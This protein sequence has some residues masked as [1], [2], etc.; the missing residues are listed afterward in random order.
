MAVQL[1]SRVRDVFEVDLPV[2][3][4]L[5]SPTIMAMAEAV[6]LGQAQAGKIAGV[7]DL[8]SEIEA[9]GTEEAGALLANELEVSERAE[10]GDSAAMTVPLSGNDRIH[11][12]SSSAFSFSR[13]TSLR[14][15][16]TNTSSC[17]KRRSSPIVTALLQFGR[18]SAIFTVSE[19]FI[20][21]RRCSA[22]PSPQ[23][24]RR[25]Q[26]RAGSVIAPLQSPI[27]IAEEWAL[28]DNLSNGRTGIAFA[29]GFHPV[30]FI[31]SPER[32]KERS[33]L[34]AEVVEAVRRYWRGEPVQ[35]RSG[36]GRAG[37]KGAFSKAGA[38]RASHMA[39]R[40]T[41]H[42]D[43]RSGG[44]NGRQCPHCGPS[45]QPGRRWRRRSL[46]IGRRGTN[47]VMIRSAGKVTLMLHA[48]AGADDDHVRRIGEPAV[49]RIP[50]IPHG[51]SHLDR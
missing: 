51:V 19:V 30:D 42:R 45:N 20:R 11:V 13:A 10:A 29:T 23:S 26:I 2:G 34:T 25:I 37:R 8:L 7:E 3:E 15:R 12:R 24:P 50:Q 32:F 9:L 18:P 39:D 38:A 36:T 17:S 48:F 5:R 46:P 41:I 47:T 27:R 21:T 1:I 49:S 31:L 35:G 22:L 43:F 4:F 28:V 44:Q 16:T 33:K 14:S 40:D 6:A